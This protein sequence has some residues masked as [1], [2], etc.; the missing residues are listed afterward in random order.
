M[1]E[2]EHAAGDRTLLL[3][4]NSGLDRLKPRDSVAV[5]LDFGPGVALA[6]IGGAE[7]VPACLGKP[8][9]QRVAVQDG[10]RLVRP[11]HQGE[12]IHDRLP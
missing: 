12:R 9:H 5:Q 1:G 6:T 7:T 3:L 10:H 8:F 4:W 11:A 2:R